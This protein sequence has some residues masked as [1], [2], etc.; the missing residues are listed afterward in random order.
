MRHK[1]DL[2][3]IPRES[4]RIC[5]LICELITEAA[6]EKEK[7]SGNNA[8]DTLRE[9]QESAPYW[10]KHSDVIRN[11][12]I[13]L[14]EALIEEAGITSRTVGAGCGGWCRRTFADN[15]Q[16]CR[17]GWFCHVHGRNS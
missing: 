12:F 13:P 7:M 9:W 8:T 16:G 3:G 10:E 6:I 15:G 4:F 17:T 5:D 11:M 2:Q 14:T 1:E